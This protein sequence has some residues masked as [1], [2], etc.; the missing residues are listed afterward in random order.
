MAQRTLACTACHGEQ[1][2]AGPDGY[3]PRLAGKPAAY[4]FNQLQNFRQGRRH[5]P[6]MTGLIDTLDDAYLMAIAQHFSALSVPYPPP[7]RSTASPEQAARGERL[8]RQGD[9]GRKLPACTTCHGLQLTG[10]LPATPGL[11]GLPADYLNAQLG[12]WQT[13]QRH[14]AEPDCMA[15]VVHKL[16]PGE[17]S[18]IARWLAAQPVPNP[19][20]AAR[21]RPAGAQ[22]ALTQA[23]L[24]CAGD[25]EGPLSRPLSTATATAST[26]DL[27]SNA[28]P[29]ERGA[30]LARLGNCALCHT[31]RGGAPY[32]G[33]RAIDTPF[34]AVLSGNITPDPDHGIGRWTSEDFWR[35]LHHGESKDGRALY[36]AFPYT[37]YTHIS[38]A[39]ADALWAFLKTVPPSAQ[40]NRPHALRWPFGTQLALKAWRALYFSPSK[41]LPAPPAGVLADTDLAA[42]RRGQY[43]V[44]GLGHCQECHGARNVLG[45]LRAPETPDA[46]GSV[47]PGEPWFAPGLADPAGASVAAWSLADTASLLQTGR[48]RRALATGPMAEVVQHGT[49]YLRDADAQAMALYL[50]S[51]PQKPGKAVA[52]TPG[53]GPSPDASGPATERG[54]A[55][56]ASQCADCHGDHGEGRADAYPALAGNRTVTQEPANNLIQSVL[57]GGF[58]VATPGHPQPYGMPPFGLR[59]TDAELAATL[60]YLRSHWGNQASALSEFDINKFRRARALT[61]D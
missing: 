45:A 38:R 9:P 59:L 34:G 25:T 3:Y 11:L 53:P 40:A 12:G 32:A 61:K 5:F 14:A 20:Q 60:S 18:A 50:R 57:G 39:D 30:Y 36:P 41:G 17:S 13:G 52:T 6:A 51:L 22:A 26:T 33:G 42:W 2:R 21:S 16:Q 47:L 15:Q 24:R 27:A 31:Q 55:L 58:A 49:Q 28:T 48:N 29:A 43:L 1:G 44:Q 7:V 46:R 10:V 4:L 19:H 23:G 8:V 35:A 37:S 54:R 56:Y